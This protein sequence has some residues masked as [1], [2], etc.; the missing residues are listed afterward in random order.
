MK[1][2]N[3]IAGSKS[4]H[5]QDL[6]SESGD[7]SDDSRSETERSEGNGEG[8]RDKA[9][10]GE[11]GGEGNAKKS[12]A[13]NSRRNASSSS[14]LSRQG[15]YPMHP[16]AHHPGG[17][18]FHYGPMGPYFVPHHP[19]HPPGMMQHAATMHIPAHPSLAHFPPAP[20]HAQSGPAG[21]IVLYDYTTGTTRT[22]GPNDSV[23]GGDGGG[24]DLAGARRTQSLE[25][26]GIGLDTQASIPPGAR[27]PPPAPISAAPPASC[28][29]GGS[30]DH[31]PP[32]SASG[33][34]RVSGGTLQ[35]ADAAG[36]TQ[37]SS[38]PARPADRDQEPP[39]SSPLRGPKAPRPPI[40][41]Q[42]KEHEEVSETQ[43]TG[44]G[45]KGKEG[46]G[47]LWSWLGFGSTTAAAAAAA[48]APMSRGGGGKE[49]SGEKK[50]SGRDHPVRK[51]SSPQKDKIRG[52]Q[53]ESSDA[54]PGHVPRP[55]APSSAAVT[56]QR[57]NSGHQW[58]SQGSGG[59][60]GHQLTHAAR[61][62]SSPQSLI[63]ELAEDLGG[64]N[65]HGV[66]MPIQMETRFRKRGPSGAP[67]IP[68]PP[69][70][71]Q[72]EDSK[73]DDMNLTKE[74]S[75]VNL[76]KADSADASA[77]TGRPPAGVFMQRGRTG[78]DQALHQHWDR[79]PG[80]VSNPGPPPL[81]PGYGMSSCNCASCVAA[82][83]A[84]AQSAAGV[85]PWALHSSGH[86]GAMPLHHQPHTMRP[87]QR[88]QE[89]T[90]H[91][92]S[93]PESPLVGSGTG[94][95]KGSCLHELEGEGGEESFEGTL[96]GESEG[97][98][99]AVP[100]SPQL[101]GGVGGDGKGGGGMTRPHAL[102]REPS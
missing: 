28:S 64:T 31:P 69:G 34:R 15:S 62:D 72:H 5:S 22:V 52:G 23:W 57:G 84:H 73:G 75:G 32:R 9:A 58:Q 18:T 61:S 48:A 95:E 41:D 83:Y 17:G 79:P 49:A 37:G 16:H 51:K 76:V 3:K 100:L 65:S 93:R 27:G 39:E 42:E 26:E 67:G 7:D 20:P 99:E 2:S 68:G 77:G 54:R 56:T 50:T 85:P 74:E 94:E 70:P 66:T 13:E 102:S 45:G 71:P 98:G 91:Q 11:N 44:G 46:S 21:S 59:F 47:G 92:S 43:E 53:S 101:G 55:S 35:G 63:D 25:W 14:A 12:S 82:F 88:M 80:S 6:R 78:S 96:G 87:P 97:E 10:E 40:L 4:M 24:A 8:D 19:G 86:S 89:V 36:S 81:P 38:P 1:R 90:S 30:A 29:S 33:A 60:G